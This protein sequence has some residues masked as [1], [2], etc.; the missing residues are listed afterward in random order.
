MSIATAYDED[1]E[2]T[3]SSS[4]EEEASGTEVPGPPPPPVAE[5]LRQGHVIGDRFAIVGPCGRG[6][7]GSTFWASDSRTGVRV[8][9]KPIRS[10]APHAALVARQE[11]EALAAA[12][13]HPHLVTVIDWIDA[14]QT[15]GITG[16]IVMEALD[17]PS[18]ADRI[19]CAP[20]QM[21]PL[22]EV[23]DLLDWVRQG[24]PA[25]AHLHGLGL[26]FC[27]IKPAHLLAREAEE[28]AR[29]HV[30]WID[31]G[32]VCRFGR[33][34]GP[35]FATNGYRDPRLRTDG[36][37]VATDIYA[38]GRT[39]LAVIAPYGTVFQDSPLPTSDEVPVLSL[40]PALLRLLRRATDPE[41]DRRFVSVAELDDALGAVIRQLRRIPGRQVGLFDASPIGFGTAPTLGRLPVDGSRPAPD[42]PTAREVADGLPRP[43]DRAAEALPAERRSA[44][45]LPALVRA[46]MDRDDDQEAEDILRVLA[47][48][49]PDDWRVAW[50]R[51]VLALRAD[52]LEDA[53]RYFDAVADAVPGETAP[54]LA[55]AATTELCG[56]R[57]DAA[58][59]YRTVWRN[60]NRLTSAVFGLARCRWAEGDSE[61][62]IAAL[63]E[64]PSTSSCFRSSRL[65]AARMLI[66]S[67]APCADSAWV[68]ASKLLGGEVD[69]RTHVE[70]LLVAWDW[71][72]RSGDRDVEFLGVKLTATTVRRALA[73]ALRRL[74]RERDRTEAV[75]LID[76]SHA[77]RPTTWW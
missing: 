17:G 24:L 58:E 11:R 5:I 1:S 4:D 27:D 37:S 61:G 26:A 64:I 73:S 39:I 55:L 48:S 14:S 34:G 74:A 8:V 71:T 19:R 67:A 69:R 66:A 2:P 18:L 10:D 13:G 63:I 44:A 49:D 75:D 21:I 41:P 16:Y 46:A 7:S 43:F 20:G 22:R 47:A 40:C 33:H 30:K 32:G 68:S 12:F 72:A 52:R 15:R 23:P 51:G 31:V 9:V 35:W 54:E 28:P 45:F 3:L 59:V 53:R 25:I 6:M 65:G 77:V 57:G 42:A 38:L 29:A 50:Y 56:E 36:P 70:L 60:D 62:A 76:L